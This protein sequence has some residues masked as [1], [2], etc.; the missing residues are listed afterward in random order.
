MHDSP[1]V[2]I[3]DPVFTKHDRDV[4]QVRSSSPD[5]TTILIPSEDV[6]I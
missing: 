4:L 6:L 2:P 3:D 1:R 5:M